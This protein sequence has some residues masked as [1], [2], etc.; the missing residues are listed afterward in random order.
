MLQQV[1]ADALRVGLGL[2]AFVD[3]DNHRAAGGLGMVDRLDGLRHH[4][5]I[6]RH[7]QNHD[8]GDIGTT[9]AHF[10]KGLVAGRIDEGDGVAGLG[11]DLIGADMLGDAAG[12]ASGHIRAAD[13]VKKAGLA[14]VDMTH[15]RDNRRPRLQ[16]C[17][18]ILGSLKTDFNIG[19]GDTLDAMAK[20]LRDQ[21]GG[22][23]VNCLRGSGHHAKLH[24]LFH[25]IGGALGHAVGE[26]T[27]RNG[28][29]NNDV[30]YLFDLW[31]LVLAHPRLF[32]LASY[33]GQRPLAA[34][35][36]T[37]Q[38]LGNGHFAGLAA[39][40]TI[41]ARCGRAAGRHLID[42]PAAAGKRIASRLARR[43]RGGRSRTRA[44]GTAGSGLAMFLG[45][46]VAATLFLGLDLAKFGKLGSA[47]RLGRAQRFG[48]RL[49]RRGLTSGRLGSGRGV[50]IRLFGNSL[51]GGVIGCRRCV[52]RLFHAFLK[53][54]HAGGALLCGQLV[55][56]IWR[57]RRCRGGIGGG[58]RRCGDWVGFRR[59][60]A[61]R[62]GG[63]TLAAH[64][65]L[66]G[67]ATGTAGVCPH[68]P[69]FKTTEGQPAAREAEFFRFATVFVHPEPFP[70]DPC[71][72][73]RSPLRAV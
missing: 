71:L 70:G 67:A 33:R 17:R 59:G 31:L 6:R 35:V 53:G 47:A 1:V 8:I 49:D 9:G 65:H 72:A 21:F 61:M 41:T 22:L 2:V 27:H 19:F 16:A 4:R 34:L 45:F 40:G 20:L 18:I 62:G 30:A 68:L 10:G 46:F 54:T 50:I 43:G 37:R 52:G 29:G 28:V 63:R 15:H 66:H 58:L 51:F 57:R 64:F 56:G 36:V 60:G 26:F 42:L 44:G 12:L 73:T 23:A 48:R 3:S 24:Q 5:I 13:G 11:L 7:N 55:I 38:R 14:V 25:N 32:A 69:G 39:A